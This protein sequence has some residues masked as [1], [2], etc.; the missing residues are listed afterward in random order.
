MK[1][2]SKSAI[3]RL[4]FFMQSKE[5]YKL[6]PQLCRLA[7]D[8]YTDVKS[9][10]PPDVRTDVSFNKVLKLIEHVEHSEY[11]LAVELLGEAYKEHEEMLSYMPRK[12]KREKMEEKTESPTI[13]EDK[14]EPP[15]KPGDPPSPP[16]V[17]HN[18]NEDDNRNWNDKSPVIKREYERIVFKETKEGQNISPVPEEERRT[19]VTTLRR[20]GDDG[21]PGYE[22]VYTSANSPTTLADRFTELYKTEWKSAHDELA[23]VLGDKQAVRHLLWIIA[24][25][26]IICASVATQQLQDVENSVIG[27]MVSRDPLNKKSIMDDTIAKNNDEIASKA[28]CMLIDYRR[29]IAKLSVPM[30]Q[31]EIRRAIASELGTSL[32][33]R[34]T[35]IGNHFINYAEK[36]VEI[37]WLMYVHD[38]PMHLE[39]LTRE[40]EGTAFKVDAYMPYTRP[41][42]LFDYCVWPVVRM[43]RNG[44]VLCKGI[45][46]GR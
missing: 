34:F 1:M 32:P 8:E 30:L 4:I 42:T 35:G 26:S 39:W 15:S 33:R 24:K 12:T 17:H 27:I 36:C 41:G 43:Q 9:K 20:A 5:M 18:L 2:T 16:I 23:H 31:K 21:R 38:P 11:A 28:R 19:Y 40:Q 37:I 25:S 14:W 10:L 29:E 45:A 22:N 13:F 46:Q 7:K 6:T 3:H 44:P